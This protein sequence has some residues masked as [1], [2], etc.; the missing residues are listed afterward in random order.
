MPEPA[1]LPC[2]ISI[3][4]FTTLGTTFAATCST[5]PAGGAATGWLGADAAGAAV[6]WGTAGL[7]G[8]MA[9]TA[10]PTPADTTATVA[11]PMMVPA[12]ER[13]RTTGIGAVGGSKFGCGD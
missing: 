1:S 5:E 2:P 10:A 13:F 3:C 8:W 9:I 11:A 12:R 7:S 6:V 4:S